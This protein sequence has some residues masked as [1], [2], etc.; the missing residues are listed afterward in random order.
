MTQEPNAQIM[1]YMCQ[2]RKKAY[3]AHFFRY[4]RKNYVKPVTD[5][6]VLLLCARF[7]HG[8]LVLGMHKHGKASRPVEALYRTPCGSRT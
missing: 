7:A 3:S 1:H 6:S 5:A 8:F 4:L 2:I